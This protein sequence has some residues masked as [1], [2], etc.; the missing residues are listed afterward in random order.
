MSRTNTLHVGRAGGKP[1]TLKG[2]KQSKPGRCSSLVFT[3]GN[4]STLKE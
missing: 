4:A 1:S 2:I 3:G